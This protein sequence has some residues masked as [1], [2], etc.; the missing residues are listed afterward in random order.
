VRALR[1]V[2]SAIQTAF[3]LNTHPLGPTVVR[4]PQHSLQHGRRQQLLLL[5]Q[6]TGWGRCLLRPTTRCRASCRQRQSLWVWAFSLRACRG[7]EGGWA[8]GPALRLA[9]QVRLIAENTVL[10]TLQHA[11]VGGAM[12]NTMLVQYYGHRLHHLSM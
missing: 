7:L 9:A 11:Y 3:R 2:S 1:V 8:T 5:W 4:T 6:A 10:K 12:Q